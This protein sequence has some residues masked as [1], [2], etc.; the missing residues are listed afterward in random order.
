M[1][2]PDASFSCQACMTLSVADKVIPN[3]SRMH[4]IT[5]SVIIQPSLKRRIENRFQL[6]EVY[7]ERSAVITKG[8]KGSEMWLKIFGF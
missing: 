4:C 6:A 2:I 7:I 1:R 8:E 3:G 5:L